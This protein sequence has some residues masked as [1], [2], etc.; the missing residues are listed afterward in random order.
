[1]LCFMSHLPSNIAPSS[2]TSFAARI[3]PCMIDF[4]SNTNFSAAM[5][6]PEILPATLTLRAESVPSTVPVNPTA[7]FALALMSPMNF[8][9]MRILPS[10]LIFPSK[11][12]F[13]AMSV[14]S[15]LTCGLSANG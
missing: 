4:P 15:L 8:P 10:V 5:T 1:M 3:S 2:T 11:V 14:S 7:A 12:V 13:A 9:S 6:V